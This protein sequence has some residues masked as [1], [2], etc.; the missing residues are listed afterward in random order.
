[1]PN[2]MNDVPI[3]SI[4]QRINCLGPALGA[5]GHELGDHGIVVGCD[6]S[7]ANHAGVDANDTT[8]TNTTIYHIFFLVSGTLRRFNVLK[9]RSSARQE[10]T[11]RI[12]G[13]YTCLNRVATVPYNGTVVITIH[14]GKVLL[15]HS[16]AG[17][18][19]KHTPDQIDVATDHFRYWMLNLKTR[20]HFQE[21]EVLLLVDEELNR[22]SALI[23]DVTHQ[24]S[25]LLGHFGT[26]LGSQ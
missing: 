26:R 16:P 25:N 15:G 11:E 3:Q 19:V 24:R 18:N 2:T 21:E 5:V 1:M 13:I 20:I 10:S 4:G 12:L 14:E 9:E 6:G 8:A 23:V 22:T 7:T 17:R